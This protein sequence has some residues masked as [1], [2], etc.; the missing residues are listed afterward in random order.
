MRKA[1][2]PSI[3]ATALLVV[4]LAGCSTGNVMSLEPGDCLNADDLEGNEISDVEVLECSEEHTAEIFAQ[5]EHEGD[6]FPGNE[7]LQSEAQE[8]CDA[9]FENYVGVPYA[10]SEF[11][12]TALMPSEDSWNDADDRTSLCILTVD[13]PVTESLEGANR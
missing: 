13:E 11:H 6:E 2:L 3:A 4:P 8:T 10:E 5:V 7:A 9:E 1:V 12:Y